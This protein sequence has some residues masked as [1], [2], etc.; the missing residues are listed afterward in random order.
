M[1]EIY[2]LNCGPIQPR[3]VKITSVCYVLLIKSNRGW[4]L[5]DSGFGK[6][7]LKRNSPIIIRIFQ[8]LMGIRKDPSFTAIE[9][10]KRLGIDP[11]SVKDIIVTHLHLDHAGGISDFPWA[12]VHVLQKEY[13]AAKKRKGKIWIGYIHHQWKNHQNWVF[14]HQTGDQWFD[15]PAIHIPDLNPQV[16]LIP[17][18]GHT[19]GHCMVAVQDHQR[20][21][22][23]G[24]DAIYPF[25]LTD[26]TDALKPPTWMK[27]STFSLYI[28]ALQKLQKKVGEQVVMICGH[29]GVS[30]QKN[31]THTETTT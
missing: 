19:V 28:P 11:R 12:T 9:Q 5:I 21:I 2:H 25:Y 23:H 7:D 8:R 13:D 20:W 24:G 4:M 15:F 1:S 10:V 27:N 26:D 6:A 18:P 17:T 30:F 16:Y 14:Y 3:F 29:D 31:A 22:L